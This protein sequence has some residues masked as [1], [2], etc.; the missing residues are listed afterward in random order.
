[1]ER[2]KALQGALYSLLL[3]KIVS[4]LDVDEAGQIKFSISNIRTAGQLTTVWTTHQKNTNV[5]VKWVVEQLIKLFDLNSL[6]IREVSKIVESR[7]AKAKRL[8]LYNIGLDIETGKIIEGSW[9]QRL[10]AQDEI[11]QRVANRIAT[12][13]QSKVSLKKFRE[14]FKSDFLNAKGSGW[15]D[16]YFNARSQD[17]FFQFD[18]SVQ[19]VYRDELKLEFGLYTGTIM[20][21]VKGGTDGTRPW[22]WQRVGNLYDL[23]TINSWN[24]EDWSGKIDGVDVKVQCGGFS[25]RH[26]INFISKEMAQTLQKRGRKLNALN[27]PKPKKTLV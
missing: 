12:A 3:E 25:C 23:K 18:R 2:V 8:L 24:E 22:C 16:R 20:E 5:F 26:S 1:M 21:P 7:E 19:A 15:V 14:D 27:P 6:Y 4:T 10:A 9:L 17:L 13:I 11:K